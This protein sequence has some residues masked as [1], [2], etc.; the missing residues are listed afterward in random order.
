MQELVSV[1]VLSYNN[2]QYYPQC[3]GSVLKQDYLEVEIVIGDD[4]SSFFP[5]DEISNYL[6]RERSANIRNII[7][8]QN[9]LNLGIVKNYRKAIE[10]SHGKYIFYLAMDDLFYDNK[11]LKNSVSFFHNT[12]YR[13]FTGFREVFNEEK[14]LGVQ[15]CTSEVNILIDSTME[16]KFSRLLQANI[17]AGAATPF[18]KSL[19]AEYGFPDNFHHLED[20]PRYLSLLVNGVDI[21][22]INRILIK[23]RT[24]GI[25]CKN[26][27]LMLKQD[28]SKLF[29]IYLHPPYDSF[30]LA[31]HNN[32]FIT[33]IITGSHSQE[34]YYE[35]CKKTN[36]A[37]SETIYF[38]VSGFESA[39]QNS[40]KY[41]PYFVVFST[42]QYY[43]V[44]KVLESSGLI[45]GLDFCD[46]N[47]PKLLYIQ[48][49]RGERR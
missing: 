46:L 40:M 49:L 8:Y 7:I 43:E 9:E 29:S 15:P 31:I 23:Y 5:K 37:V 13:I 3:L 27:D 22:F 26:S 18:E 6:E 35:F 48:T 39:I 45:E 14:I 1:I 12:D 20:W 47:T 17:I 32:R 33:G 24:D 34:F 25:T 41:S 28:Y 38:N 30:L 19:V 44:A 2:C 42:H 10:Y 36:I 21:G 16:H 4:G 11:V